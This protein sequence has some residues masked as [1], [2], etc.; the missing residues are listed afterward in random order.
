MQAIQ[1][2]KASRIPQ[3]EQPL[4]AKPIFIRS[5][6]REETDQTEKILSSIVRLSAGDL[7]K[8][9]AQFRKMTAEDLKPLVEWPVP[10]HLVPMFCSK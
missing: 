9:L 4:A 2:F 10:V 8:Q 3:A 7:I 6:E 1:Q 5:E